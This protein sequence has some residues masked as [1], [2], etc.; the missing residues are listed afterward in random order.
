MPG[1]PKDGCV[2]RPHRILVVDDEEGIR[3]LFQDILTRAGYEVVLAVDGESALRALRQERFELLLT[4]LVMPNREGIETIQT[5]RKTNADL[6]II[7]ISG[8]FGGNFLNVAKMLGAN[9]TLPKPISSQQLLAKVKE[10]L[11]G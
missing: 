11:H 7:A 6:K 3:D 10:V 9:A 4:D 2:Q 8:A 5:I 1:C